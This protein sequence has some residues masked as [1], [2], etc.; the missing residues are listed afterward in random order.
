[1]IAAPLALKHKLVHI[2]TDQAISGRVVLRLSHRCLI[3]TL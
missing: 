1:M 3:W 2:F